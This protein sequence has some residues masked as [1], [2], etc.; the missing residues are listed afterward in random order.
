MGWNMKIETLK[1]IGKIHIKSELPDGDGIR[2]TNDFLRS[3]VNNFAK[4]AA[5]YMNILTEAPFIYSEKQLHSVLAPAFSQFTEAF[6]MEAPVKRKWSAI[7]ELNHVDSYGWLDYWCY[8]RTL[9]YF[10]EIKHGFISIRTGKI[11]E[12]NKETWV[13]ANRQ[14]EV[15]EGGALIEDS[16]SRGVFPIALQIMPIFETANNSNPKYIYDEEHKEKV[17]MD[18]LNSLSPRPNWS[19]L[20]SIDKEL[21]GPYKYT[22]RTEYYPGVLFIARVLDIIK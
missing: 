14:L 2:S 19:A 15:V 18:C 11:K 7:K 16:N 4:Q 13:E 8:Y 10:I 5:N 3:T 9:E 12:F 22:S 6:L 20:W 17:V 1:G 21:A